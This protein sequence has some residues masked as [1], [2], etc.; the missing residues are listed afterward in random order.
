MIDISFC[1]TAEEKQF[2][3]YF[4][5]CRDKCNKSFSEIEDL[6]PQIQK[7]H[8]DIGKDDIFKR[9]L[10]NLFNDWKDYNTF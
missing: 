8:D 1:Y 6:L 5:R 3:E 10:K 2:I 7:Y 9:S 4:D